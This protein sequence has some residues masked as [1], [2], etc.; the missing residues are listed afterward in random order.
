MIQTDDPA[1]NQVF[2][3]DFSSLA[4]EVSLEPAMNWNDPV[5]GNLSQMSN[6]ALEATPY[7]S[8]RK[9]VCPFPFYTLV[10]HSDLRV[11]VCCVDWNKKTVVGDLRKNSLAEIWN[12]SALHHIQ[13]MHLERR[14]DELV[15]C[16]SCTFL[17]TAPD[18]LDGLSAQEYDQ[19]LRASY[20]AL[21][22]SW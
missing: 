5:E 12:G 16:K 15:G 6:A 4:D 3:D 17:H 13:R 11:S 2:I 22:D 14:R 20:P 8:H 18:N 19:R 21:Q 10:I 7:F 9:A 1:E